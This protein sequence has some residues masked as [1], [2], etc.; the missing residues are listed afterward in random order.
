MKGGK[1]KNLE[2]IYKEYANIIYKYVYS[3]SNNK[4]IAEE[5]TQETFL[6]AV[7]NIKKFRGE[8]K[9]SVWLCQI[10]KHSFFKYIKKRK[11]EIPIEEA[12]DL[13]DEKVLIDEICKRDETD[14]L[15]NKIK[16]L[17][18]PMQSVV[19]LRLETDFTFK[20]IG[21]IFGKTEN[22]AKVVFFRG[23]ERLKEENKNG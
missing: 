17:K 8:C 9:I 7:E 12:K 22:W 11:L 14:R 3:L 6:I 23:K 20:E 4:D 15:L 1:M 19:K 13:V 21:R 16:K 2:D 18:E 5:I 10:A